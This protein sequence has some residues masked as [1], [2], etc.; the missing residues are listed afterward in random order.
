MIV[1][2][3]KEILGMS[4]NLKKFVNEYRSSNKIVPFSLELNEEITNF[5]PTS[6]AILECKNKKIDKSILLTVLTKIK[7]ILRG[8]KRH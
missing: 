1:N 8:L 2:D 3:L 7:K 5:L 6:D 4:D